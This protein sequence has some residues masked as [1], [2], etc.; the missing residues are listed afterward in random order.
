MFLFITTFMVG[1]V[2]YA[3]DSLQIKLYADIEYK[4]RQ[5]IRIDVR[6]VFCDYCSEKQLKRVKQEGWRRAYMERYSSENRM[7]TGIRKLTLILRF[8]KRD[9]KDMNK[10]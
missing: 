6:K 5:P 2:G 8:A 9:F 1:Q 10:E 3:K 4:N 7:V